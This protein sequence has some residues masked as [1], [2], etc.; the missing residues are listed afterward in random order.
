LNSDDDADLGLLSPA[1]AGTPAAAASSDAAVVRAILDT[2]VALVAAQARLGLAPEQAAATIHSVAAQIEID[3]SDVAKR[4]RAG[5]NPV[6]PLLADF[7]AAV[8]NSD[9]SAVAF[10]HLG[11]TSQ[12]ILDTA[13]VLVAQRS[14]RIIV[15]DLDVSIAAL[16]GLAEKHRHTAMAARTLTQHSVPTTFGLKCAGWLVGLFDATR[17]LRTASEALPVQL[18]GAAGTLASFT[19]IARLAGRHGAELKLVDVLAGELGLAAPV[20]PWHTRRAPITGLGDALTGAADALGKIAS[21]IA[22][23]TRTEIA[24]VKERAGADR[25][26]SSAM[27]QKQNPVLSVL[28]RSAALKAPGLAG[29]LHRSAL[30]VDERPDGAWHVEWSTLRELLRLV[31]GA[32][33]LA[34]ELLPGLEVNAAQMRANMA[35]TGSLIVSEGLMI[36]LGPLLGPDKVKQLVKQAAAD[37]ESLRELLRAEQP[38]THWTDDQLTD[39]LDPD[40]YLG[41]SGDLI[42]RALHYR[43]G[44]S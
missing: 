31:G 32:S 5:G 30:A 13:L 2:E 44:C 8:S 38:L 27:P 25:G 18:G 19:E 37:P 7:R 9:S 14:I 16:S 34:A 41:A 11:A 33:S 12:D 6:I 10:V 36:A 22:V 26:I 24:E 42:D 3:V 35:I 23:M 17:A 39:L 28:I 4:A 20:L 21:D 15:D 40:N 43:S 1:W 29:E